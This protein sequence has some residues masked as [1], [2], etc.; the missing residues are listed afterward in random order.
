M[1]ITSNIALPSVI[2]VLLPQ[3]LASANIE[4]SRREKQHRHRKEN[5]VQHCFVA[6]VSNVGVE[7]RTMRPVRAVITLSTLVAIYVSRSDTQMRQIECPAGY[8]EV[9]RGRS[10]F[11][12]NSGKN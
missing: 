9:V 6:P 5:H 8:K 7:R 1:E 4:D 10:E 2:H 3:P 12:P 11:R